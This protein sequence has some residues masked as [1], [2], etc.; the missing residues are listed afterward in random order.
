MITWGG[1]A[2]A[3][4]FRYKNHLGSANG[5]TDERT[6]QSHFNIQINAHQSPITIPYE[7]ITDV[8]SLRRSLKWFIKFNLKQNINNKY[9]V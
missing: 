8:S 1:E 4:W 6:G 3:L 7:N 2:N 9:A 5:A